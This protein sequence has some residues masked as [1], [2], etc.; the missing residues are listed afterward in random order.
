VSLPNQ[1]SAAKNYGAANSEIGSQTAA[2]PIQKLAAR[3]C[4]AADSEIGSDGGVISV[5]LLF[6]FFPGVYNYNGN[7]NFP[8]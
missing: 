7:N 1:K 6:F 3:N 5:L 8:S 2:L 4:V